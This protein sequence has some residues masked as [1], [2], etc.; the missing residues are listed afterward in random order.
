MACLIQELCAVN[1]KASARG[2]LYLIMAEQLGRQHLERTLDATITQRFDFV[3]TP[4]AIHTTTSKLLIIDQRLTRQL[5][6]CTTFHLDIHG[7][8]Y[9]LLYL[10]IRVNI[11]NT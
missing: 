1:K 10:C 8:K 5:A 9:T 11:S 6:G 2:I 7:Q 4:R 3:I